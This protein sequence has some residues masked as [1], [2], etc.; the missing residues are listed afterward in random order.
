MD[1]IQSETNR[2]KESIIF[3]E[4]RY[5][6]SNV[7]KNGDKSYRCTKK[8]CKARIT[9][10]SES[11]TIVKALHEH[12]HN[13]DQRKTEAQQL[14]VRVRKASGDISERPSKIIRTELQG[15]LSSSNSPFFNSQSFK[16]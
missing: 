11:K 10:D 3:D 2:G 5:R 1:V 6:L 13:V 12:N 9:T 16:C 14:R 7:L 15:N 8:S 4:H